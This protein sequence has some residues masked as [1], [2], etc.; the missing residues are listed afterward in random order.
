MTREGLL[1]KG[2]HISGTFSV[3]TAKGLAGAYGV[4]V[5]V[6]GDDTAV[7][8]LTEIPGNPG[9]SVT[10]V[11]EDLH[12]KVRETFLPDREMDQILWVERFL[13]GV[14]FKQG[15]VVRAET[16]DL[17]QF[18]KGKAHRVPIGD[19][20]EGAFWKTLFGAR[21]R[22]LKLTRFRLS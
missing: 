20:S 2:E 18:K 17:T 16:F 3:H 6:T 14:V 19:R 13:E 10:D 12:G 8:V 21:P 22:G 5:F 1:L 9:A 15:K 7:F 4:D 11:I